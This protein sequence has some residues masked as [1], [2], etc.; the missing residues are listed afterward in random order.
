FA[1]DPKYPPGS[2]L[3]SKLVLHNPNVVEM[4][5]TTLIGPNA[6]SLYVPRL[7]EWADGSKSDI[8][9]AANLSSTSLPPILIE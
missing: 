6:A 9:Y 2:D 8:V 4:I 1:L 3:I 5:T 7:T